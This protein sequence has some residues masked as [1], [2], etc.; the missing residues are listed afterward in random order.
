MARVK[1]AEK[2]TWLPIISPKLFHNQVLGEILLTSPSNA[3][4]RIIPVNLANLSRDPRKQH[5]TIKFVV[6]AAAGEKVHT[7]I[8][9]YEI[10]PSFVKRMI[11]KGGKKIDY[12]FAAETADSKKII[13]KTVMIARRKINLSVATA[14]RKKVEETLKKEAKKTSF[15]ELMQSIIVHSLQ[16][17]L[18]KQLSK[19]Y[20]LK[21]FEIRNAKI[22]KSEKTAE[23]RQAVKK[24]V[25]A[26]PEEEAPE[27]EK[28][29]EKKEMP[30]VKAK[31]PK[32]KEISEE[33]KSEENK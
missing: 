15:I 30:E 1:K 8:I 22:E 6:S 25:K 29:E 23:S 26:E 10:N 17:N 20:P 7:E 12:S 5:I 2:K 21:A 19:I 33:Q 14:L 24:E 27:E 32:K 18:K 13:L 11:R 28:S 3:V 31:Q 4:G 9:G 16:S